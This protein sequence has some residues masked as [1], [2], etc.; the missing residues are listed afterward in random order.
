MLQA[1]A[2]SDI[3]GVKFMSS[4]IGKVLQVMGPVVDVRFAE[5]ELPDIYNALTVPIGDKQLTVEVAQHCRTK[6]CL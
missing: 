2:I 4:H 5:N 3:K 1:V 6:L